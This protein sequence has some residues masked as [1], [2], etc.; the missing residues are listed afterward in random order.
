MV[1]KLISLKTM[2][3][4]PPKHGLHPQHQED[5]ILSVTRVKTS[6]GANALSLLLPLPQEPP[7]AIC[8][9]SHLQCYYQG[10]S[11][12]AYLWLSPPPQTPAPPWPV[13]VEH[14]FGYRTAQPAYTGD[15]GTVEVW[16]I[17]GFIDWSTTLQN[18]S[19]MP[20]TIAMARDGDQ[21]TMMAFRVDFA[22]VTVVAEDATSIYGGAI[23]HHSNSNTYKCRQKITKATGTI[24]AT[25]DITELQHAQEMLSVTERKHRSRW[26]SAWNCLL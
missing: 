18:I 25:T 22:L 7:P 16:M 21:R 15:N 4:T 14:R 19:A 10:M 2:H 11:R 23:T 5:I 26:N 3:C 13:D 1:R 8:P 12:N 17:D 9:H 6:T 24:T 20:S